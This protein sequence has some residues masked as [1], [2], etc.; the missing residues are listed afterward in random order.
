MSTSCARFCHC[1]VS[2]PCQAASPTVILSLHRHLIEIKCPIESSHKTNS[3]EDSLIQVVLIRVRL[4]FSVQEILKI[5]ERNFRDSS[6]QKIYRI[7]IPCV[8]LS[9]PT[10]FKMPVRHR[11]PRSRYDPISVIYGGCSVSG[12]AQNVICLEAGTFTWTPSK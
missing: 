12:K 5:Q 11:C 3:Y 10:L 1:E 6:S 7:H 8:F 4:K 2:K 9:T